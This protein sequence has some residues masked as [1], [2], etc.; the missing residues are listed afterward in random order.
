MLLWGICNLQAFTEQRDYD[1]QAYKDRNLVE[2][3]FSRLRQ[4]R[5]G[6][7]NIATRYEKLARTFTV[8]L[9]SCLCLHLVGLIVNRP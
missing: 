6:G 5:A 8:M 2:R 7:R 3:F 1:R 4:F 9:K